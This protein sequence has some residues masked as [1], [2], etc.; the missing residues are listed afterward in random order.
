MPSPTA[1]RAAQIPEPRPEIE[2]PDFS[3]ADGDGAD[4][5]RTGK[6]GTDGGDTDNGDG[7]ARGRGPLSRFT[8]DT[9]PLRHPA[10]RRLWTSSVV[11]SVGSQLTA[12]AVPKQIYDVTGSSTWIGIASFAALAPLVVFGL[13]G[14]AIAD[15]VD[16]RRL[17][18]GTNAGIA[19]TSVAFWA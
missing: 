15:A 18:L 11:T 7:G 3:G 14:G 2:E 17:L 16:R 9:R 6:G 10:Y 12:V 4:V 5:E 1:T 19:V 13:W 8:I